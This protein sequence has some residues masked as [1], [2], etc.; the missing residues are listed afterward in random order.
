MRLYVP[1]LNKVGLGGGNSFVNNFRKHTKHKLQDMPELAEALFVANPMWAERKDFEWAK[2]NNK[3]I[4]LRLDNIPEDWNNRGTAIS[5]LQDYIEWADILIFQSEWVKGKYAEFM[6]ANSVNNLDQYN[7][8]VIQNGVDT[9]LFKPEGDNFSSDSYPVILFVKSSRNE[10]KRYPEV[11]EMFRRYF[12]QNPKTKLLLVGGFADDYHKYNFGFYNGEDYKYLGIIKHEDMPVIY[13]SA[14][15]LLFPAYADAAPN[16]VLEAMACG[17]SP[18]INSYGGGY[19]YI[20][21]EIGRPLLGVQINNAYDISQIM[22]KA[23]N[24]DRQAIR[25]HVVK[26]FNIKDCVAKYDEAIDDSRN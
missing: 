25:E 9:E 22:E 2:T 26:N 21:Q 19:E 6:N 16:T 8:V 10:N 13:R 12:Y 15:I 17:L 20:R 5:K 1:Q 11:M 14:D 7:Y 18:I 24:K 3:P 4:I 23:M